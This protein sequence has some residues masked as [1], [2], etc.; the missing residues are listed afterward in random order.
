MSNRQ[1]FS[2][3]KAFNLHK[4][5]AIVQFFGGFRLLIR[6]FRL[7]I[8]VF[9]R[10][11]C[12]ALCVRLVADT[13]HSE[14]PCGVATIAH[15]GFSRGGYSAVVHVVLAFAG[16]AGGVSSVVDSE[17]M[18]QGVGFVVAVGA[19]TVVDV[20]DCWRRE[21]AEAHDY[22]CFVVD[23][24]HECAACVVASQFLMTA[25]PLVVV[26]IDKASAAFC[27]L[28]YLAER[29]RRERIECCLQRY[30]LILA[31]VEEEVAT[32]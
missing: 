18:V 11:K 22:A 32:R 5:Y 7:L 15:Q 24:E 20:Q 28:G 23:T 10:A 3:K 9:E 30:V 4:R 31:I 16:G 26:E 21:V 2:Y 25:L 17:G 14:R 12:S 29:A 27:S 6:V 13:Q 8:C 1:I 19:L